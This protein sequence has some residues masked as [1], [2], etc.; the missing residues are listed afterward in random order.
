MKPNQLL[1]IEE[2]AAVEKYCEARAQAIYLGDHVSL[3]RVLGSLKIYVDTRD[4]SIAPHL[5]ME[6]FWEM[7]VTQAIANYVRPGMRCIDVGA[8]FGY[9]TLLLADLT[10]QKGE[11]IAYEPNTTAYRLLC[12][13][14]AVNGFGWAKAFPVAASSEAGR[15]ALFVDE[16][17]LGASSLKIF[18]GHTGTQGVVQAAAIDE[19][20]DPVDFVKID[21]QGHELEVLK[22]MQRT[23]ARSPKIAIAME[24]T[25][26]DHEDPKAALD[27]IQAQGLSIRNIGTDGIVRPIAED[28]ALTP[29]TGDHRMLWLSHASKI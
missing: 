1:K 3:A 12:A 5:M 29:E 27:W 22:G 14:L 25:P 18:E 28:V 6:G 24:F 9:Y 20:D 21:V 19:L 7:W 15:R 2:R 10:T 4:Q 17:R 26:G 8:S 23:I 11:V 16:H 13:S